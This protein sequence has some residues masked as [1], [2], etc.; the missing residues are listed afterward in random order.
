VYETPACPLLGTGAQIT[1]FLRANLSP[2][3]IPDQKTSTTLSRSLQLSRPLK[4]RH[5]LYWQSHRSIS[6]LTASFRLLA[7]SQPLLALSWPPP[8][9]THSLNWNSQVL[10]KHSHGLYNRRIVSMDTP[11]ASS[12]ILKP[13]QSSISLA[14]LSQPLLALSRSLWSFS[15]PLLTLLR[16]L[17]LGTCFYNTLT[18][19]I[20]IQ[21]ASTSTLMASRCTLY[22]QLSWNLIRQ[23]QD[24]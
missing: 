5:S 22:I 19:S 18:A 20:D 7:L 15:C 8:I 3:P 16:P 17:M 10:F 9:L 1:L 12:S 2:L 24:L 14:T 4:H 6:I 21:R 23:W 13:L 11:T